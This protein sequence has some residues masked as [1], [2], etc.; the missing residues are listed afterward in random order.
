MKRPLFLLAAAFLTGCLPAK[1]ANFTSPRG[2]YSCTPPFGWGY[3]LDFKEEGYTS[4]VFTGPFD[5]DFFLGQ[6]SL[7]VRWHALNRVHA[8]PDGRL[9][10]YGSAEDFI[11][12]T[13]RDVY[14][15]DYKLLQP[16][17]RVKMAG[18]EASHFVV[19]SPV[20]APA[21]ARWG[22]S[23][24]IGTGVRVNLRRHAYVVLPVEGG[25]YAVV[26]PAT[27]QGFP[28]Y[29]KAFNQLVNG[30]KLLSKQAGNEKPLK[31]RG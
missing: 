6:P 25:F 14:G 31:K 5:P 26:Y 20:E 24:E 2:D 16:V 19:L 17:H 3:D 22:I 7:I 29:E 11:K 13:L 28:A 30:F 1:Y 4:A 8:L 15:P 23:E 18:R 9:E 12:N 27:Q 21:G 10:L